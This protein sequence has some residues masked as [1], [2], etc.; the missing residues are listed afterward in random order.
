MRLIR[1][2]Y[3]TGIME[4]SL[5]PIAKF[6]HNSIALYICIYIYIYVYVRACVC[7]CVC[8][9]ECGINTLRDWSELPGLWYSILNVICF[10]N[11]L[12]PVSISCK[13]GPHRKQS[14][15]IRY[16]HRKAEIYF[17]LK[18]SLNT[19]SIQLLYSI[20]MREQQ[21]YWT[22]TGRCNII[23]SNAII[24]FN[25]R[26]RITFWPRLREHATHTDLYAWTIQKQFWRQK[27]ANLMWNYC[28]L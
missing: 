13:V 22:I 4:G 25:L 11:I 24:E 16:T 1:L 15:G 19:L 10:Y 2:V 20:T 17:S 21:S 28:A 5:Y 26:Q 23:Q 6:T 18:T 3:G 7:M 12:T 9:W 14:F 8:V 27:Y